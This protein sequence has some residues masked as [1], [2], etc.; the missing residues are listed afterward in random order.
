M[1]R[2]MSSPRGGVDDLHVVALLK[3]LGHFFEVHVSAVGRVIEAP[4]L[5]FPNHYGLLR[6]NFSILPLDSVSGWEPNESMLQCSKKRSA[7]MEESK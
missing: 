1:S 2:V 5:V 4:V 7:S 3:D 6:H